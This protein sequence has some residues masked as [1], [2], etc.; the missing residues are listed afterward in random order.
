MSGE[1]GQRAGRGQPA[2]AGRASG[3]R[4]GRANLRNGTPPTRPVGSGPTLES[5]PVTGKNELRAQFRL[6]RRTRPASADRPDRVARAV[7]SHPQVAL[8]LSNRP[9]PAV[10]VYASLAAEPPTEALRRKLRAAGHQVLLPV[11]ERDGSLGWALDLGAAATAWGVASAD[12]SIEPP[13]LVG[14]GA[15]ALLDL[16]VAVLLVPA[17]AATPLGD[18]LGQG[19]GYYDRLLSALSATDRGGPLRVCLVGPDELVD[20]LPRESHDEPVDVVVTA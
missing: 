7:L 9:L 12:R 6:A 5:P 10:A 4:A 16:Q 18:R 17:L 14:R 1:L 19:G 3:Q 15:A 13:P 8:R 20:E 11:A 2:A